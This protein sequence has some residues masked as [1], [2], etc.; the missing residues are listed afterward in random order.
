MNTLEAVKVFHETF[1][2]PVETKPTLIDEAR[3]ATRIQWIID[4]LEELKQALA[5][6]DIV[7]VAD[8]LADA[9]YFL[10]GTVVECGMVDLFPSIFAEVQ[11]SNMSKACISKEEA[12]LTVAK[13]ERE[14]VE[15]GYIAKEIY[16]VNSLDY[17]TIYIIV[18]Q[19]DGKTLKSINY[20]PANLS[21]VKEY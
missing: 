7:E 8:A 3:L 9:R 16:D 4:E 21:F 18:R 20:S 11:R 5:N 13:Y 17:K 14:G 19:P 12:E 6:K 1:N 2:H 15:C 10:D